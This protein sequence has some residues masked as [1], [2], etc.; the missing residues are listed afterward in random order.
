MDNVKIVDMSDAMKF[1]IPESKVIA[2]GVWFDPVK[3]AAASEHDIHVAVIA[4]RYHAK[5][6][7]LWKF[8]S[9]VC[10][11]SNNPDGTSSYSILKQR[12]LYLDTQ[13]IKLTGKPA[14]RK[15]L[16]VYNL[17][18]IGIKQRDEFLAEKLKQINESFAVTVWNPPA[19]YSRGQL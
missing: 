2:H 17:P 9:K 16:V 12:M 14:D 18:G 19:G 11:G 6:H 5:S 3:I 15:R 10:V 1:D 13:L 4:D 8:Q 7:K